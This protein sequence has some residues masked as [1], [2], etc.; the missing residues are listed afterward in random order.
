M[1][2]EPIIIQRMKAPISVSDE[3]PPHGAR[4]WHVVMVALLLGFVLGA[5]L[6]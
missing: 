2:H 6:F 1:S 5:V 4:V 3:H